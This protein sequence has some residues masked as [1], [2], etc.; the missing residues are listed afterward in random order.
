MVEHFTRLGLACVHRKTKGHHREI[1]AFRK[2][3][4][5]GF[6]YCRGRVPKETV[7]PQAS[8]GDL[9][10]P[11]RRIAVPL[12]PLG[13]VTR[14]CLLTRGVVEM[15]VESTTLVLSP[16]FS[17]VGPVGHVRLSFGGTGESRKG[18]QEGVGIVVWRGRVHTHFFLAAH[19][20]P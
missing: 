9:F 3:G 14:Q 19:G 11:R 8:R 1:G 17:G 7:L 20:P 15:R 4:L 10:W 2:G 12:F 13:R 6:R 5:P 18:V 16:G